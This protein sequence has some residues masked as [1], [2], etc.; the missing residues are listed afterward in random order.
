VAEAGIP[1]GS[2]YLRHAE[3]IDDLV[4]ENLARVRYPA[5][6]QRPG[7]PAISPPLCRPRDGLAP[8]AQFVAPLAGQSL[9]IRLAAQSDRVVPWFYRVPYV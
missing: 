5:A 9:L 2:A 3:L 8:G 6:G 1:R 7:R 4:A